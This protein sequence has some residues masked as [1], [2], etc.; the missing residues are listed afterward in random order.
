MNPL[1]KIFLY[2]FFQKHGAVIAYAWDKSEL[3]EIGRIGEGQRAAV[4]KLPIFFEEKELG[5]LEYFGG[6]QGKPASTTSFDL[7][8]LQLSRHLAALF[9]VNESKKFDLEIERNL[10]ILQWIQNAKQIAPDLCNWIGVYFKESFLLESAS[11]DLILGPFMGEP[12]DHVR[13]PLDKGFCGMALREE[14]VINV[15]DV[16]SDSR[17]IACSLSTR[18]ELVIPLK[19]A[20]G[21][22]IAELDIDSDRLAAFEP[23]VEEA[24]RAHA[25]TFASLF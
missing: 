7:D 23:E 1:E 21:K 10:R 5:Y 22:S 24:F 18:S 25:D 2:P 12:T 14:R 4:L 20:F 3:V 6:Q 8:A 11:T 15:Q 9:L 16:R 19:D 17:H 13:I